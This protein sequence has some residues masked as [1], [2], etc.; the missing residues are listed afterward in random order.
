MSEITTEVVEYVAN[1]AQLD[2]NDEDKSRLV[3]ELGNI[4][5]YIDQLNAVNTED[6]DPMMHVLDVRNVFREDVVLPS[7]SREQTFAG[8]PSTD[9]EYFLVPKI[10][11][12]E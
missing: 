3:G 8:A 7:L 6:I 2:L 9:G 12:Q 1:L 5:S 11:D 10:L 4:L